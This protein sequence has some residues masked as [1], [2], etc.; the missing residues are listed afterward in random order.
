MRMDVESMCVWS[1]DFRSNERYVVYAS[2]AFGLYHRIISC[3]YSHRFN[4]TQR[5]TFN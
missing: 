3:Y 5:L 4:W 1:N 2:I